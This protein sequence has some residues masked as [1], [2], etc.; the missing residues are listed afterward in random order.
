TSPPDFVKEVFSQFLETNL[1]DAGLFPGT[2][3]LEE[4]VI[5]SI[6]ELHGVEDGTG[7]IVSGGTEANII[8]L[9]AAR[10]RSGRRKVILPETAHFSLD[11]ACNLLGLEIV[12]AEVDE[13]KCVD[14]GDVES[15]AD[16]DT[17]AIVGI[18]GST[19]YGTVDDIEALSEIAAEHGAHL[20]VDAAFGGFVL[21][22]LKD[23][24]FDLEK[25]LPP[26]GFDSITVDPHKMGLVPIPC[27]CLIFRDRG[28]LRHIETEAPYLTKKRQHTI[29][30][31]RSGAPAAAAYAAFRLLGKDGYQRIVTAC[32]ENTMH[33]YN[34]LLE[35][36]IPVRKPTI[37]ILVFSLPP[38]SFE[39]LESRGWRLS[40]TREG[41]ARII[42][43]PHV[44]RQVIEEFLRD[45]EEVLR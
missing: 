44:T 38:R 28:M 32:M 10:N 30:G 12:R 4:W 40:M 13:D 42:V 25:P 2:A 11:K 33:L 5:T 41:E 34:R 14:I 23:T 20:H 21:P 8:A 16:S 36:G 3:E 39:A 27:G 35:L 6:A 17:C 24:G 18:A 22:F 19:E 7:F 31:T 15:R 9:W 37:N 29:V 43:M 1:G 26:G 45:L